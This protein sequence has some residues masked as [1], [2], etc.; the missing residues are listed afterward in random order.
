MTSVAT[1]L[2]VFACVFGGALLGMALR[3]FLPEHHRS[4]ESKDLIRSTMA[5]NCTTLRS[6]SSRAVMPSL[7][8]VCWIFWPCSSVP[9]RK[10]TS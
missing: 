7:V 9:V 10:N 8:A 5:R 3:R 6:T 1:A 2:V 4:T